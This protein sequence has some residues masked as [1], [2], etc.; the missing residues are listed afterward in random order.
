[1]RSQ[2]DQ[3]AQIDAA[4]S[5]GRR[6][7]SASEFFRILGKDEG[8]PVS[9]QVDAERGGGGEGEV[10]SDPSVIP[11]SSISGVVA[12]WPAAPRMTASAPKMSVGT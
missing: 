5:G 3:L 12:S 7:G 9:A 8:D 1:L 10:A 4:F 2:W 6:T 11:V